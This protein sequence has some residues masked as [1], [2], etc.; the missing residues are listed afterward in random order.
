MK[1][2]VVHCLK[3]RYAAHQFETFKQPFVIRLSFRVWNAFREW[4]THCYRHTDWT[5]SVCIGREFQL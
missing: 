1:A 3:A 4:S 5:C 2:G